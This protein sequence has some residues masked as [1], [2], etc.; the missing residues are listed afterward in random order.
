MR[1]LQEA[2]ERYGLQAQAAAKAD[3]RLANVL[4]LIQVARAN[5]RDIIRAQ[6]DSFDARNA[7]TDAV[8]NFAIATLEFYRDTGVMQ[9]KPDGMWQAGTPTAG[10]GDS[11]TSGPEPVSVNTPLPSGR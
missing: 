7:A 10:S 8:V 9:V 3:K 2:N 5:T 1:K 6:N 11:A 4:A